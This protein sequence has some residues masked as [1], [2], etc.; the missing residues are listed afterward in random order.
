MSTSSES[1]LDAL[2]R[3]TGDQKMVGGVAGGLAKALNVDPVIVR[4]GFVVLTFLGFAGPI[5]YAGLWVFVPVEGADRSPVAE[6]LGVASDEGLRTIGLLAVGVI[7][8][9]AVLGDSA[10]GVGPSFWGVLWFA[11]WAALLVAGPYWYFVLRPRNKAN[12]EPPSS[13]TPQWTAPSADPPLS[14][15]AVT[16]DD[17]GAV[18]AAAGG[19]GDRTTTAP[20][21]GPAAGP[22]RGRWSPALVLMTLSAV[23]AALGALALW[24]MVGDVSIAPAVY[25][26]TALGVVAGG[27]LIGTRVGD[28]GALIPIGLL[29][30]PALAVASVAPN[31]STGS[32]DL[33]PATAAEIA[34]PIDQGAGSIRIDLTELDDLDS[35]IGRTLEVSH[36]VGRTEIIVPADLDVRVNAS[37]SLGG[38]IDVLGHV[39][40]GPDVSLTAGDSTAG[41]FRIDIDAG[42]GEIVVM[43]S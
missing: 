24:S 39:Q 15:L 8:V 1:A 28:P 42:A 10:W 20:I 19:G 41:A 37:L 14:T 27:L 36:G 17:T 43:R 12:A 32:I 18:A 11:A 9:L 33:R 13:P 21:G 29:L 26:A 35:L 3:T 6:V 31:V 5:L 34:A 25:V 2:R 22:P 16:A 23:A 4:I 38:R 30:V 7:A 40:E